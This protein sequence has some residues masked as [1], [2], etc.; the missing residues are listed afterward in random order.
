MLSKLLDDALTARSHNHSL[1]LTPDIHVLVLLCEHP[2]RF[3]IDGDTG[4]L[5]LAAPVDLGFDAAVTPDKQTPTPKRL[6][7]GRTGVQF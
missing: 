5:Q 3:M 1:V 2:C 4:R 7:S 6:R